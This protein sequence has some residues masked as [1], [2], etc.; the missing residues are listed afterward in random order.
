MSLKVQIL[1]GQTSSIETVWRGPELRPAGAFDR[2]ASS[3][4]Q[5]EANLSWEPEAKISI[6]DPGGLPRGIFRAKC[7][8]F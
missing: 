4:Q 2:E 6:F 3:R 8:P 7:Q 5:N 1:E